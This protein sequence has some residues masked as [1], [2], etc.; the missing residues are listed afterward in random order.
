[1]QTSRQTNRWRERQKGREAYEWV[2]EQS[3]LIARQADRQT[4]SQ[5]DR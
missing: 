4:G 1:M 5:A 2:D 3:G